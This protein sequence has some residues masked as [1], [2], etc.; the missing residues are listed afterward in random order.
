MDYTIIIQL[1]LLFFSII[2]H[3]FAHGAV[4]EHLGDDTARL[5]GRLTLNPVPHIDPVGSVMLPLLCYFT[6]APMFGWAKPVP[7]NEANLRSRRW[8]SLMVAAVGP[9]SNFVLAF[10]CAILLWAASRIA[11]A[12]GTQL[13]L[14]QILRYGI[15]I[16]LYLC[17]FN[18]LPIHPLDGSRVLYRLLP[19]P[20]SEQ[21][22]RLAPHGFILIMVL[23]FTG[24]FGYIINPVVFWLYRLL[25]GV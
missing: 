20:W 19:Y 2:I 18:L 4:A 15:L 22:E 11:L 8:G 25:V 14:N 6:G 5:M 13:L 23:M 16:N 3:E 12:Y 7:V 17:V 24:L 1:P 21:F 9:L 10:S